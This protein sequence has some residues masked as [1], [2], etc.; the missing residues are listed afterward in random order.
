[1]GN[2][3][4]SF[5]IFRRSEYLLA[6]FRGT[7]ELLASIL[8]CWCP[9][10]CNYW[11]WLFSTISGSLA[12]AGPSPAVDVCDFPIVSA[13]VAE[14]ASCEFL[15]LLLVP[16]KNVAA[17]FSTVCSGG[18]TVDDIHDDAVGGF[19]YWTVQWDKLLNYQTIGLWLRGYFILLS[20]YRNIEFRIGE[21]KK[22]S[23]IGS[24][25][26][27]IGLS[28][29]GLGKNYQL[30]PS[31]DMSRCSKGCCWGFDTSWQSTGSCR[32]DTP[33]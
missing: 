19:T 23:D 22:L 1:M 11:C 2:F 31:A 5:W 32:T 30:P 6:N 29:I 25:P 3:F 33:R 12:V 27:F 7:H 8:C 14:C 10:W 24:R 4:A 15:L 13:A 16:L 20:K 18:P 9:C 17:V 26:Q 28:N 21:C